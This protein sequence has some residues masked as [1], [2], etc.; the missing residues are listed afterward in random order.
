M[1]LASEP[2]RDIESMYHKK[3]GRV[4]IEI[5]LNS[6][7]QLFNSF[8]PAP[9]YEK[10]IDTEAEHYI[11]DTVEDFPAKTKFMIHI[12]L[13]PS[14]V[15]SQEAKKIIPAIHNHFRYKMLVTERKFRSK[16]RFGRWS[17]LVGLTF[18]AISLVASQLIATRTN[19]LLPQL[20]S[21]S[22]L[23]IGWVAMWQPITVFLYEL[24][25]II[26]LKKIYEKISTME[27]EI[28]PLPG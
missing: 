25:P 27:I 21:Y 5:K 28:L 15:E 13:P 12:Y 10:E 26:R 22:L 16:F 23:I 2:V 7:I 9:F 24:W 14:L 6:I 19:Y 4:L 18:L 17:L 11:V 3:D 20:L 8:D 1:P